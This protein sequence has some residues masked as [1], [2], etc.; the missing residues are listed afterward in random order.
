MSATGSRM[1]QLENTVL[2]LGTEMYKLRHQISSLSDFQEKFVG[3]MKGLK[4]ILDEKGLITVEDFEAA[5]ELGEAI[6]IESQATYE[7][8]SEPQFNWNKK[9]SH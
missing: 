2:E 3:T 8:P 1:H 9:S 6:S 5:V 7:N 4:Q